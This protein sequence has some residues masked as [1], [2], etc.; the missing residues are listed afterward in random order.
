MVLEIKAFCFV[1][2]IFFDGCS[3]C[4]HNNVS[5]CFFFLSVAMYNVPEKDLG[6][7]SAQVSQSRR[8]VLSGPMVCR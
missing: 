2:I 4:V 1:G 8:L 5:S 3:L 6:D 7:E